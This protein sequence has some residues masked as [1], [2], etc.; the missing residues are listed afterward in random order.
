MKHREK[1]KPLAA[2]CCSCCW[3]WRITCRHNS[4]RFSRLLSSSMTTTTTITFTRCDTY[5]RREPSEAQGGYGNYKYARR[6]AE[7]LLYSYACAQKSSPDKIVR[8]I[9]APSVLFLE[10]DVHRR[11]LGNAYVRVRNTLLLLWWHWWVE[12]ATSCHMLYTPLTALLYT[13]LIVGCAERLWWNSG[14]DAA[15]WNWQAIT[16]SACGGGSAVAATAAVA[17]AATAVTR[18]LTGELR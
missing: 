15:V 10:R 1:N 16:V 9:L 5:A 7:L 13:S 11:Q 3:R 4:S 17:A 14:A 6:K 12:L 8:C 18:N 2:C